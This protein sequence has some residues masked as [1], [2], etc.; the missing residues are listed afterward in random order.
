MRKLMPFQENAATAVVQALEQGEERVLVSL[1]VG[2]GV[3]AVVCEVA[4]RMAEGGKARVLVLYDGAKHRELIKGVFSSLRTEARAHLAWASSYPSELVQ[5]GFSDYRSADLLLCMNAARTESV[6]SIPHGVRAVGI[7]HLHETKGA[8]ADTPCVFRYSLEECIRDG[9]GPF[10]TGRLF[11][12]LC[13]GIVGSLDGVK[14]VSPVS[15][16]YDFGCDFVAETERGRLYVECKAF[17]DRHVPQDML[18]RGAELLSQQCGWHKEKDGRA[19]HGL[20]AVLGHVSAAQ[21]SAAKDRFNVAVWDI[22]NLLYYA[23]KD[24]SLSK[25]LMEL[26]PFPVTGIEPT[27]ASVWDISAEDR[28]APPERTVPEGEKLIERLVACKSGARHFS[29]YEEI[30]ADAIGYLFR[31]EFLKIKTQHT[32]KDKLFRMDMICS[33]KGTSEFWKLL[34]RHYN[35]RFVVFEFKNFSQKVDQNFIYTTEKYLF[36]AALRSVAV[37]LS[38]KGFSAHA[39]DAADGCL[40]E[41]GKLILG[42]ND[43]DLIAMLRKKDAGEE[44]ADYLL[45]VLEER[46]MSIGK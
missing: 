21:K 25:G 42:L 30:C 36:G 23:A 22:S 10:S 4:R 9:E 26:A 5:G 8:F 35:S 24:A 40:K 16:P 11:E 7:T 29:Q 39:A 34:I 43:D 15:S 41:S 46:L 6:R 17:R 1:P 2:A 32:T 20:L 27:P 33:L 44:P 45:D 13:E 18:L 19:A 37:I 38:R 14:E 28:A 31:T 12:M 3:S